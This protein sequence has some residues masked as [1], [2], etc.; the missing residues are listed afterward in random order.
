VR[1][2][3]SNPPFI[4]SGGFMSDGIMIAGKVRHF[5][6]TNRARKAFKE[7]T[8]KSLTDKEVSLDDED[9]LTKICFVMM[10]SEDPTLEID[11]VKDEIDDVPLPKLMKAITKAQE[12]ADPLP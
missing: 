9:T 8:G 6:L 4:F 10:L 7:L 2:A 11:A 12:D 3:A 5:A 1:R